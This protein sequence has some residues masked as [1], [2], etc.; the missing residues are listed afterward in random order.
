M[1]APDTPKPVVVFHRPG[2][3]VL[4]QLIADPNGSA[5]FRMHPWEMTTRASDLVFRGKLVKGG[6]VFG[7]ERPTTK[8][9]ATSLGGT[10]REAH[11][12]SIERAL[13]E[14]RTGTLDKVVLA[15][16]LTVQVEGLDPEEVVRRQA[17]AHPDSFSW[18]AHLPGGQTW[19]GSS[20]EPLVEGVWPSLTTACL[21][22]TRMAH[23]GAQSDPWTMKEMHEQQLV[24]DSVIDALRS[25]E[26]KDI[27]LS[28]RETVRYGPIEHLRTMVNFKAN[29]DLDELMNALHPTPAVGGTP[30]Q[31]AL[32]FID[33]H[34]GQDRAYY[35]GWVG[36]EQG[37]SISF[38]VNLRCA[39]VSGNELTAY[40]G[41]GIT[42]G[43]DPQAEWQEIRNK[44]RSVL[45]PIVHWPE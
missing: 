18:M 34:E 9:S 29:R 20:P 13:E 41:G 42:E 17:Q 21:A 26:S 19:F 14:I 7:A 38:Y 30:R 44:L 15:G 28:D 24:T 37:D 39:C 36:L 16:H 8:P 25:C 27:V 11:M 43:S 5:C 6:P 2:S 23:T 22:G 10:E 3:L 31:E 45:D 35:T 4:E 12:Q 40:A 33:A 1:N 32:D